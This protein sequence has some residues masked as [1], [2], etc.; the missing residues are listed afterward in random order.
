MYKEILK[1]PLIKRLSVIQFLAYFGSWFSNVAIYTMILNFGVSSVVNA[2]V[3]SMFALPALLAPINGAIVDKFI[4]KNFMISLLVV[5]FLMTLSYLLIVDISQVWILI[6]FIYIRTTATFLFFNS[7]MSLLPKILNNDEL[8]RANELHSIIWSVTFALGMA[9]GGFVVDKIGIYD[10]IKIDSL[11]FLVAIFLF[12]KIDLELKPADDIS[13]KT[14]IYEGFFYLGSHKKIIYLMLLHAVVAL[15]TFDTLIN[16]LTDLNYKYVISI[17]LAIGLLNGI[18]AVGLIVGPF[19][20]GEKINRR[21]L[22]YFFLFQGIAIIIFAMIEE[23]FYQSLMV[24]F[25]IGFFTTTLWSY[26]YTLIQSEV[27]KEYLGRVL[28]YNEMIFMSV[29]ILTTMFIGLS[30]KYGVMLWSITALL[31][32]IFVIVGFL[33]RYYLDKEA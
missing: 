5:E 4:S 7:E 28:A 31:G 21:T 6:I 12:Y 8:K 13:I 23:S 32:L 33:Y 24:M 22:W 18:R 15:T 11:L 16:L 20:I 1:N 30:Y 27:K 17:P 29:S 9:I 26:T 19:L 2:I 10:S 25:L 14:L 3:V